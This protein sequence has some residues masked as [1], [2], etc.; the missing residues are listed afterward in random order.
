MIKGC[1]CF[2]Q[3]HHFNNSN[4]LWGMVFAIGFIDCSYEYELYVK[5]NYVSK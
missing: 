1:N 2:I 3:I 5:E 4:A